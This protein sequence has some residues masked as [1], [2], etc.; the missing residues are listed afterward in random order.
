MAFENVFRGI[1]YQ[2]P[3]RAQA[4]R[5][6]QFLNILGNTIAQAQEKSRY[7]DRL[8]QAE[9]EREMRQQQRAEDVAFREQQLDLQ[10]QRLEQPEPFNLKNT[11]QRA[12]TK[13]ALTGE[14]GPEGRAAITAYEAFQRPQ[15]DPMTGYILPPSNVMQNLGISTQGGVVSAP[16][17]AGI[18]PGLQ[19]APQGPVSQG[20]GEEFFS[21]TPAIQ[22]QLAQTKALEEAKRDIKGLERFNEG[23]LQAANFASRME[24]SNRIFNDLDLA[25]P[26]A[27]EARTGLLGGAAELLAILPLGEFGSGAGEALVRTFSTPEQQR[28]LNAAENWIT[29]NLRKESGAVI[30]AEEKANE[31]RKYFPIAGDSGAVIQQKARLREK[32]TKGMK[33]QSAGAFDEIFGDEIKVREQET[34]SR[35]KKGGFSEEEISEYLRIRGMR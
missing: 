7:E 5:Q 10:R 19:P 28:Y 1:D 29:A 27:V 12:A 11:A 30:G 2:A 32:V 9:A 35:L 18:Q 15:V 34:R 6:Q 4:Q 31:Y 23:Q 16:Q 21:R 22:K 20:R 17:D 26:K 8:A 33:G 14:L 24:E 25:D 13:F 3:V